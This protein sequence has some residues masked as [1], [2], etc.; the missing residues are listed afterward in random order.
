MT[1]ENRKLLAQ[2]LE[3]LSQIEN[4][5]AQAVPDI[6]L[7]MDQVIGFLDSHLAPSR[8]HDD[9][10][11]LT[12]TMIN[13]YSKGGILPPP[14]KKKYSKDHMILLM[15]IYYYKSILS[16]SDLKTVLSPLKDDY[17][18]GKGELSLT[19][20]YEEIYKMEKGEVSR[21]ARDITHKLEKANETFDN[22]EGLS[23]DEK[24][25]LQKFS[26]IC[27]LAFD[28]FLKK[29]IIERMIDTDIKSD[30]EGGKKHE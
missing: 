5:T 17:F 22:V 3:S 12:K 7:Y 11:I 13:N 2:M 8:R 10:K 1:P 25:T 26:L 9:D 23:E 6:D 14:E 28:V 24:I 4:V 21:I 18:G 20:I 16:I 19:E 30:E 29:A 27:L 15:F